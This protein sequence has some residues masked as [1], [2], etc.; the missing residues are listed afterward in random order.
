MKFSIVI[1]AHD[2]EPWINKT[3]D[4]VVSQSFKDFEVLIACDK[5]TDRTPEIVREYG[6]EPIVCDHGRAGLAR[7]EGLDRAQGEYVLFLDADDWFLHTEVLAMLNTVLTVSSSDILSFGFIYGVNGYV[8]T[9]WNNGK[10]WPNVWNKAWKRS[11]IGQTRFGSM[12]YADDA[13][14]C[15][16]MWSKPDLTFSDWDTPMVYYLYPRE[17][18]LMFEQQNK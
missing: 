3:L 6:F 2:M 17:G 13:D 7:N 10:W 9:K 5:C 18:S 4:S 15:L 16:Q 11:A 12:K 14:F 8:A 1:P